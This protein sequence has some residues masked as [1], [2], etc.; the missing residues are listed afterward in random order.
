MKYT[1]I[2]K[3][4]VISGGVLTLSEAQAKDRAHLLEKGKKGQYLVARP[5]TFKQGETFGFDGELDKHQ[6]TLLLSE[7]EAEKESVAQKLAAQV[8]KDATE[9][10][11]AEDA[12]KAQAEKDATEKAVAE[13]AAKAQAEKDATEK[14]SEKGSE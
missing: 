1:V 6:S 4:V 8:E 10:A 13:D 14:A 2:G 9:K 11:A 12:A 7:K 5:V 3:S